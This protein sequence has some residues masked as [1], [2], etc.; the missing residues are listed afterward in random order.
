[1]QQLIQ[2]IH[3]V[4]NLLIHRR[5]LLLIRWI[6]KDTRSL[7]Y[8]FFSVPKRFDDFWSYFCVFSKE[9]PTSCIWI[10][11]RFT[12]CLHLQTVIAIHQLKCIVSESQN[13]I[14]ICLSLSITCKGVV[15]ALTS[16]TLIWGLI[17]FISRKQIKCGS[18][19]FSIFN[20]YQFYYYFFFY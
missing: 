10:F 19:Q 20:N 4:R 2:N 12:L 3:D 18:I 13:R 6:L 1:M 16:G 7:T 17:N 11:N 9:F 14:K 5:S 15:Y 8:F